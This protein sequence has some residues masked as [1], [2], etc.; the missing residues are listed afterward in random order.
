MKLRLTAVI[1]NYNYG[2]YLPIAVE[3]MVNQS[4]AADELILIDD[5]STDG[6]QQVVAEMVRRFPFIRVIQH[7]KNLGV[8]PTGQELL[9]MATGDFL[10]WGSAD[11]MVLPGFFESMMNLLEQHPAAALAASVPIQFREDTGE[12]FRSGGGMPES[13]CWIP[14]EDLWSVARRGGLSLGGAW[15]FYRIADLKALGGFY[16]P[17]RWLSDWYPVYALALSG[18]ICWTAR[19]GAVM[20]YH[21]TNYSGLGPKNSSA[22]RAALEALAGYVSEAPP[23]IQRGFLES[24]MLGHMG[25]AMARVLLSNRRWRRLWSRAF[26]EVLLR[27]AAYR[28]ALG[29]GRR[30]VATRWRQAVGRRTRQQT[31][32]DLSAMKLRSAE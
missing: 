10:Y 4:R 9:G 8:N 23:D 12:Q 25:P 1:T 7:Q 22:E 15:A 30:F 26:S 6:S 3:A 27:S 21:T 18:G 29:F 19:P 5:A 31:K 11:D 28:F 14:P 17:L 20:R 16:A 24:G 13:P 2:R 32:I